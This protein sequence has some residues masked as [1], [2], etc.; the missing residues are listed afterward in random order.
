MLL[1]THIEK[2]SDFGLAIMFMKTS[3]LNGSSHYVD[4]KKGSYKK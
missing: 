1:K 2:M 3:E 4:E